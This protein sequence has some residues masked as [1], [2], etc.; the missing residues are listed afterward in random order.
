[1]PSD[2][3]LAVG[4]VWTANQSSAT[5]TLQQKSDYY[6]A[7]NLHYGQ[8]R[9]FATARFQ[10]CA[11][12][13]QRIVFAWV[14]QLN[15][16]TYQ[17]AEIRWRFS[18]T[19][20]AALIPT[21]T[22]S[23]SLR[24]TQSK[25]TL[26]RNRHH[27]TKDHSSIRPASIMPALPWQSVHIVYLIYVL[28]PSDLSLVY[29]MTHCKRHLSYCLASEPNKM[30]AATRET[31]IIALPTLKWRIEENVTFF[32]QESYLKTDACFHTSLYWK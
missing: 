7:T 1:M 4:C 17:M 3:G 10:E 9:F 30:Q 26:Q 32:L 15:R 16:C 29:F 21:L 13:L 20:R 6:S 23:A 5:T 22:S 12:N 11:S 18:Y 2:P 24:G 27:R 8:I 25:P 31:S 14:L 28:Q 19:W